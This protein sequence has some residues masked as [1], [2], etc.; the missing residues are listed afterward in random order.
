MLERRGSE[1]MNEDQIRFALNTIGDAIHA[2]DSSW[3]NV[4]TFQPIV[5]PIAS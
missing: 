3:V 2:D 4:A 5:A 1:I